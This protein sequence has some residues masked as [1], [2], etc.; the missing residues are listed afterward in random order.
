MTHRR[1]VRHRRVA[2]GPRPGREDHR[3]AGTIDALGEGV[4]GY[5]VGERVFGAVTKPFLGDGS[6]AE[7]V[8]VPVA[9]G[10]AKLPVSVS[11]TDAAG[12]GLAGTA[13]A[14]STS[15]QTVVG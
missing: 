11:F 2:R 12:L 15:D 5:A 6:F 4:D 13:A 10:L 7:Y 8:T 3:F 9:V 1:C 14:R